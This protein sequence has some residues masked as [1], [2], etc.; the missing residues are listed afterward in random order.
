MSRESDTLFDGL[1]AHYDEH[2]AVPHRRAY[3]L[4]AWELTI[5][6]LPAPGARILDVGCGT[7]RWARDLI[8]RGYELTGIEPAP[9]MVARAAERVPAMRLLA[10]PV[11]TTDLTAESFDA[12]LAMGSLQYCEDPTAAFA[13]IHD[14]LVPGGVFCVLVDSRLALGLELLR[15]DRADEAHRRLDTAVGRWVVGPT[16]A[17][18]HLFDR[19]SLQN[20]LQ[21]AGF[22]VIGMHGLLV[23]ASIWGRAELSRR[24]DST[25][26]EQLGHE[27]ELARRDEMIDLG[28][29]LFAVAQRPAH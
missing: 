3:D 21:K 4:L 29:Q 25:W 23:G 13:R 7:G 28:K 27:R 2:F 18:M 26:T 11:E 15:A 6:A 17:A 10:R 1:A 16:S 8:D 24:L 22:D 5:D 9:A 12:A 20:A 14:W 19:S